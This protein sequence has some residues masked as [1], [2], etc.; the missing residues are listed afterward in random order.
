MGRA[1]ALAFLG[2]GIRFSKKNKSY[3]KRAQTITLSLTQIV[4]KNTI[5]FLKVL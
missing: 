3:P 2:R 1:F 5:Y 4:G